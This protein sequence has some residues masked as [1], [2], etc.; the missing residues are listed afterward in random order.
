MGSSSD[1]G[2]MEEGR[3]QR[4]GAFGPVVLAAR[5]RRSSR[6]APTIASAVTTAASQS[7]RRRQRRPTDALDAAAGTRTS[8][9]GS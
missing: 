7:R 3:E 2:G 1:G 6:L 8:P 5:V 9:L 4:T